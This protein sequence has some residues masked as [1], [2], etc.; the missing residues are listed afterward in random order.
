MHHHLHFLTI[1]A[2]CLCTRLAHSHEQS[3]EPPTSELPSNAAIPHVTILIE[4]P[5][6]T[7]LLTFAT[8]SLYINLP[9]NGDITIGMN[10]GGAA[11]E[12]EQAGANQPEPMPQQNHQGNGEKREKGQLDE[13]SGCKESDVGGSSD[14]GIISDQTRRILEENGV[15]LIGD[16]RVRTVT[17]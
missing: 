2:F 13:E 17:L 10:N 9:S 12:E 1:A 11:Q 3:H 8:S 16:W 4:K 14:D 15:T 5:D 6:A 7:T